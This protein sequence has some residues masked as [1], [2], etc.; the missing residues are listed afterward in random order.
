MDKYSIKINEDDEYELYLEDNLLYTS[1]NF[2]YLFEYIAQYETFNELD[3]LDLV[4]IC[5]KYLNNY[6]KVL[7]LCQEAL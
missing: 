6:K 7:K 4:N 2:L 1:E 5:Q 3:N